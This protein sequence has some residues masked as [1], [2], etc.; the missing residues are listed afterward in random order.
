MPRFYRVDNLLLD[1]FKVEA[2]RLLHRRKLDEG[3]AELR[4]SVLHL[5][6]TPELKAE[7]IGLHHRLRWRRG[8]L[9]WIEPKVRQDRPID[10]DG[11]AKPAARLVDETVF[12][13][14]NAHGAE[15]AFR[16]IIDFVAFRRAFAGKEIELVIS[17]EMHLI[18]AVA[19]LL[20]AFQF[21]HN[22]RVPRRGNEGRE[23]VEAGHQP[24]LDLACRNPARPA[25]NAGHAKAA[26]Q[27]RPLGA[28]ERSLAAIWP[29]EVFSAV[30]R[31]ENH[32]RV[33]VDTEIFDLLHDGADNV[34][35]LRHAGLLDRP[36]V[37]GRAHCLVFRRK[38]R[39][40]MHARRVEIEE[41]R[42]S[43]FSCSVDEVES[44]VA[45]DFVDG[46]HVVFD[47]GHGIGRQ[48]TFVDNSL[49]AYF[50]PAWIHRGVVLFTCKTMQK[51]ARAYSV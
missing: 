21:I 20:A 31:G 11:A 7:P 24:I 14:A 6:E 49:L 23:P 18:R 25:H 5:H 2:C 36:A 27:H 4:Y 41:E 47:S 50:A 8:A 16:E 29:G 30:V 3:L 15:G 46:L 13:V 37:F 22:V 35:E 51:I 28:G 12:V 38:M 48:G 33:V 43:I 39:K 9:Q 40:H 45:D 10:F 44:L 19:E 34:I 42:L 32:N 17:V 1:G 26:F